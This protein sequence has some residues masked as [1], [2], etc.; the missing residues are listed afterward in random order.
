M[1]RRPTTE[2]EAYRWWRETLAGLRPARHEDDPQC[3]FYKTRIVRGGP[4]VGVA[5]WL[6]QSIDP[7]TGDLTEPETLAAICNGQ[8]K[9]PAWIH[10]NWTYFRPITSEDYDALIGVQSRIEEMA[11]T[12]ARLDLAAMAPIA[13]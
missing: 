6:E 7:E 1:I 3:G 4:W 11:A 9:R 2:A 12:H 10:R 8:P 5:V 13:P